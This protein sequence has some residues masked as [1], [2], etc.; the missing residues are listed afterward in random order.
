MLFT[1]VATGRM[2]C[3][4][5]KKGC[6]RGFWESNSG[7]ME[8]ESLTAKDK[9]DLLPGCATWEEKTCS[10]V[11]PNCPFYTCCT[12]CSQGKKKAQS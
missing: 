8:R 1:E 11:V 12:V 7:P 2:N 6:S 5:G 3:R 4:G 10:A 9:I